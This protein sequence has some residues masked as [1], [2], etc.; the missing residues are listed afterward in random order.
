MAPGGTENAGWQKLLESRKKP[1]RLKTGAKNQ[2]ADGASRERGKL[3]VQTTRPGTIL[4]R[5]SCQKTA[6][7][8]QTSKTP[9]EESRKKKTR[10][11]VDIAP[12]PVEIGL[13]LE[14]NLLSQW[15][16]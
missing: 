16:R 6:S 4:A 15:H 9:R 13:P 8:C 12:G 10:C 3:E 5:L 2:A 11:E 7:V 14:E 1:W